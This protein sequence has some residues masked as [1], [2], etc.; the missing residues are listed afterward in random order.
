M[1]EGFMRTVFD[2]YKRIDT[3]K[4]T[5]FAG[6]NTASGFVGDYG[7]IADE[8]KLERVYV[9]KG[10]SGTGKSTL[11][12]RCAEEAEKSGVSVT[13][14]L[15]GSDPDSLDCVVLGGRIAILDGTA[16]H[17]RDMIY[18]G[19]SSELIDVSRFWDSR[20]LEAERSSIVDHASRKTACYASAYRYLA[21]AELLEREKS[22]CTSTIFLRE[23][24]EACI[25][26]LMKKLK[27]PVGKTPA[28]REIRTHALT[29]KGAYMSDS[30]SR[31]A[32]HSYTVTDSFGCAVP[33]MRLLAEKLTS[34][35]YS[36]TIAKLPVPDVICGIVIED[37]GISITVGQPEENDSVIN[38]ARFTSPEFPDGV[39][40]EFRLAS[41]IQ[42][43]CLSEALRQLS[44]ASEQHFA[45]EQ[46]YI[47]AM[48]FA[49][50]GAYTDTVVDQICTRLGLR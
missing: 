29:M 38:M 18:P 1:T 9:I 4:T 10:G 28:I 12:R 26:R 43:S 42:Q 17:V 16:P 35:G 5:F 49:S 6:A 13:R 34:A 39:R 27:K 21:S 50:L 33:F 11:M 15:C 8:A 14:W 48:D 30:L 36:L 2:G 20:V 24:A 46:I 3:D 45:I 32:E 23:K 44:K 40:G 31:N 41:K 7:S 25:G 47:R 37:C 19:A 22:V